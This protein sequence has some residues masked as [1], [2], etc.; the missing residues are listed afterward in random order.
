LRLW[1][2]VRLKTLDV[3]GER[4]PRVLLVLAPQADE[5]EQRQRRRQ[6][7]AAAAL[8]RLRRRQAAAAG[9]RLLR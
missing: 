7:L 4:R 1:P 5:A 9:L 6:Q 2:R 3:E 8:E